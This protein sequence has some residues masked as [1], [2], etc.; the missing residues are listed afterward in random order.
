MRFLLGRQAMFGQ[1]PPRYFRSITA[2]RLPP[3]ASDQLRSLPPAP[4]PST[5]TSY[6]S[7]PAIVYPPDARVGPAARL[8]DRTLLPLQERVGAAVLDRLARLLDGL[9][10]P[11]DGLVEVRLPRLDVPLFE[12][13][14][15]AHPRLLESLLRVVSQQHPTHDRRSHVPRPELRVPLVADERREGDA[16]D[17]QPGRLPQRHPADRLH[18]VQQ[19]A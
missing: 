1:A 10:D 16:A 17:A 2:T 12:G 7:G 6:S 15:L 13:K 19:Q 5:T 3:D 18:Q 11:A 4:L 8:P 14:L 9:L